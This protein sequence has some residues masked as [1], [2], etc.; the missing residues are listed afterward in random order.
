MKMKNNKMLFEKLTFAN[1]MW[2]KVKELYAPQDGKT[3]IHSLATMF[4]MCVFPTFFSNRVATMDDAT[5][6][7]N[8]ILKISRYI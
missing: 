1:T 7:N 4:N 2:T 6:V 3:R 8:C 5:I